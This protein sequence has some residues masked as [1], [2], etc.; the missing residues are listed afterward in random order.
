[1]NS[2]P[3]NKDQKEACV[4]SFINGAGWNDISCNDINN[5]RV[6]YVCKTRKGEILNNL[7]SM[8]TCTKN[9]SR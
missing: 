1:M 4:E 9:V 8:K 6:G 7:Y 5:D 2:Q 3:D